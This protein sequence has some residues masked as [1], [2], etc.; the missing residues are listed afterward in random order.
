[1]T[2]PGEPPDKRPVIRREAPPIPNPP[3]YTNTGWTPSQRAATAS[4]T[5]GPAGSGSSSGGLIDLNTATLAELET[6]PGI[7]PKLGAEIIRFRES[8]SFQT[9]D[10]LD[11]VNGIGPK[12]LEAVRSMVTVSQ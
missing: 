4:S 12:K 9:V 11:L 5:N 10:D 1:M 3:Q 8:Q 7:G 2:V 6:L